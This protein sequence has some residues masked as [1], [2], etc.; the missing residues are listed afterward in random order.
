[1]ECPVKKAWINLIVQFNRP[2]FFKIYKSLLYNTLLKAPLRSR[3]NIDTVYPRWACH[4][5]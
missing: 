4:A 3:L 2:L 5:A 1:M